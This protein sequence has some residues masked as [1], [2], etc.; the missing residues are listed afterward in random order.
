MK[1]SIDNVLDEN[2]F[3]NEEKELFKRCISSVKEEQKNPLFDAEVAIREAIKEIG[4]D[5]I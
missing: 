3:T 5:E 1:K 2:G 4:N